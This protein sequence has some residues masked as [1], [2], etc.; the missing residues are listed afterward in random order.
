MCLF[1][2]SLCLLRA[3]KFTSVSICF[4]PPN[5]HHHDCLP[6]LFCVSS[7]LHCLHIP[8]VS[9]CYLIP[10]FIF[11]L[12]AYTLS[13]L[14]Y[15]QMLAHTVYVCPPPSPPQ[16]THMHTLRSSF[17]GS[18]LYVSILPLFLFALPLS[19]SIICNPHTLLCVC[20]HCMHSTAP[21]HL[22]LLHFFCLFCN[23]QCPRVFLY[24]IY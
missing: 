20:L 15:T 21:C 13:A 24:D 14:V 8:S 4:H 6:C 22:F 23:L 19:L 16:H 3:S 9:V 10:D 17:C 18:F 5:H 11:L 1:G 12:P 7:N 2:P